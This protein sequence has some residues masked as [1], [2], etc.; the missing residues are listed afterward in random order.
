M[1]IFRGGNESGLRFSVR[2]LRGRGFSAVN[3]LEVP[4]QGVW[5]KTSAQFEG[6]YDVDKQDRANT[7]K[8]LYQLIKDIQLFLSF[9]IAISSHRSSNLLEVYFF[10]TVS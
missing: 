10:P 8:D 7:F 4:A 2:R 6:N 1:E 3:H 9:Y 5:L